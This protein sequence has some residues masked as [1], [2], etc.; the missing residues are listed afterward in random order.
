MMICVSSKRLFGE[1][2]L[3]SVLVPMAGMLRVTCST[4]TVRL[5]RMAAR[6]YLVVLRRLAKVLYRANRKMRGDRIHGAGIATPTSFDRVF[7]R[8][9]QMFAVYSFDGMCNAMGLRKRENFREICKIDGRARLSHCWYCMAFFTSMFSPS[10]VSSDKGFPQSP[11][12]VKEYEA[13]FRNGKKARQGD[14]Q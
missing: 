6:L 8:D 13:S 3:C 2:F 5:A 12:T 9:V 7:R 11:A 10:I 14:C 4:M 1:P